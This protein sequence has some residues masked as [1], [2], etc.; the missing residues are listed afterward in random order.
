[1]AE[2]LL[3]CCLGSWSFAARK[4]IL[5]HAMAG[6]IAE[7]AQGVHW[8]VRGCPLLPLTCLNETAS[9]EQ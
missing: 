6:D 1:M 4:V 5:A 7:T 9:D 8:L 3:P 2:Q